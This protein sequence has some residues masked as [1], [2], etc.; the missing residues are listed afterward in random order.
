MIESL[1]IHYGEINVKKQK[2][3]WE[4]GDQNERF[5]ALIYWDDEGR[6]KDILEKKISN[7]I[8]DKT[9]QILGTTWILV[10]TN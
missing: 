1:R 7:L 2:G 5:L 6:Y 4:P 3:N 9:L 8:Y 10:K